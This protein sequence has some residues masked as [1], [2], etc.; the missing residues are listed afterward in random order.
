MA[1]TALRRAIGDQLD[2][3][4]TLYNLTSILQ[5]HSAHRSGFA[6]WAGGLSP[7][8]SYRQP[9]RGTATQIAMGLVISALG[10]FQAATL[11]CKL[12]ERRWQR[13]RTWSASPSPPPTWAWPSNGATIW[14]RRK[15]CT[16]KRWSWHSPIRPTFLPPLPTTIWLESTSPDYPGRLESLPYGFCRSTSL[17][18]HFLIG[19]EFL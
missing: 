3:A 6:G 15:N 11:F 18:H 13:W 8:R 2:E 10:D 7:Q 5:S 9:A 14:Q 16:A 12:P 4:R 17:I 19:I 1:E